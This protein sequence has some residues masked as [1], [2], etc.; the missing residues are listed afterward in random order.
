[1]VFSSFFVKYSMCKVVTH[2]R[3]RLPGG[4]VSHVAGAGSEG[5]S[6]GKSTDVHSLNHWAYVL[7]LTRTSL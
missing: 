5:N 7:I 3:T 2:A 1:M 4:H 6:N